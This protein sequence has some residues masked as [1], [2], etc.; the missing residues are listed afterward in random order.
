GAGRR[1]AGDRRLDRAAA[2]QPAPLGQGEL[3]MRTPGAALVLIACGLLIGCGSEEDSLPQGDPVRGG[4]VANEVVA[5]NCSVCHTLAAAEWVGEQA[6]DLDQVAPG[7]EQVY[8][9]IIEG[10]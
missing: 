8:E 5:P 4:M 7:Y 2:L 1:R 10:P 9:T 3:C 6:P